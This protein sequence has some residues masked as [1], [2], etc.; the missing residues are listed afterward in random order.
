[1]SYTVYIVKYSYDQPLNISFY[2][3]PSGSKMEKNIIADSIEQALEKMKE[4]PM[5]SGLPNDTIQTIHSIKEA[6]FTIDIL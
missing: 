3:H 5:H 2:T 4:S 6:E 1:M